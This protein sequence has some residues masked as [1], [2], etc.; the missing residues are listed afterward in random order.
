MSKLIRIVGAI[1]LIGVAAFCVFGFLASS[2]APADSVGFYRT[3][4]SLVGIASLGTAGWLC[5]RR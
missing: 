5:W 1:L 3:L 4:Y 2:E